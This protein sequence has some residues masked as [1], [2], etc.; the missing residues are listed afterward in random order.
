MIRGACVLT[1]LLALVLQGSSGGHML[2]VE[3]TRC[4]EHGE[5]VHGVAHQHEAGPNRQA[6]SAMLHRSPDAGAEDAHDHCSA[7]TDRRDS[8]VSIA[9]A[10]AGIRALET[11]GELSFHDTKI[12]S[13]T[14]QLQLAPKTS[15][16]A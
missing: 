5:L 2:L 9:D 7:L 8:L 11:Q 12:P 4:A 16:P 15:P 1:T 10:S 3:H 13:S 14:S 6:E